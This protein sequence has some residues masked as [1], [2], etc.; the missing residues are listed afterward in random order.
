MHV[1]KAFT[2]A[3]IHLVNFPWLVCDETLIPGKQ[4]SNISKQKNAVMITIIQRC[5]KLIFLTLSIPVTVNNLQAQEIWGAYSPHAITDQKYVGLKFRYRAYVRTEIEDADAAAHLWIRVDRNEKK[6]FFNNMEKSPIQSGEWKEYSIEGTLDSNYTQIVFGIWSMYNGKFYIDDISFEVQT[7]DK[8]WRSIY[9]TDFEKGIEDWKQGIGA[10]NNGINF[11]FTGEISNEKVKN[12]KQC[13]LISGKNIPNFGTN[14]KVGKYAEVNGIKLYYEIYG[15]G[16]PLVILHGNG[17][18]IAAAA[19]HIPYFAQRYKVVAIDSRGQGKSIDN[20]VELTYELMA[21]DINALLNKLKIDSAYIWGQSDGA[22]LAIILALNHP[23]KI[24]KAVAFAPNVLTDTVGIE[25]PIFK[26]IENKAKNSTNKKEKQLNT[27]MWKH[28]NINPVKLN[29]ITSEILVMSGDRD[30]VPLSHTLD[31]F[32]N[33]PNSNLCVIPGATHG[34]AWEKPELFHE[35]VVNFFEK[36][37]IKPNT[38]DWF[39]Q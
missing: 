21:S 18:S 15:E 27:L 36:P 29:A 2:K 6:G 19:E 38:I 35:I 3:G 33:I 17:G 20:E 39:K 25:T 24:K 10:G 22:I 13:L 32:K 37:F 16:K 4:Q 7:K 1:A 11:L 31:I 14:N 23:E 34:A 8:K 30:A 5:I 9:K 28:P 12:G 26:D